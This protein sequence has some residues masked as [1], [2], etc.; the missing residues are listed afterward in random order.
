M[1]GWVK[2]LDRVLKGEA[3]RPEALREGMID[4]R[5]GGL[6]LL[7]VILG[8][9][10]GA[11]M[12]AFS[13][14]S[15][16][17]THRAGDGWLQVGFAASKVP[18]LFFLTLLITFPS[19]Y[20][21]NA[22]VGCRLAFS[23]VVRLIVSAMGVTIAVLASFGT[24]VVFFSLCTSSYPFMVLLNVVTFAVAGTLG[25][26]FLLQTLRRIGAAWQPPT[27]PI[28]EPVPLP[29]PGEPPVPPPQPRQGGNVGGVFTIWI[30][31]FGLIGAQMGWVLRPFIGAPNAPITFFRDRS[32]N[33]FEAVADHVGQLTGGDARQPGGAW[34]AT[35]PASEPASRR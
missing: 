30:V 25:M 10:Y 19:L 13:L 35:Q 15:R 17:G 28:A 9:L 29:V 8:G 16:W 27:R 33:F 24:I 20:V 22:L 31:V 11:C 23:A 12:G 6:T 3:T 14:M 7:L 1:I 5:A 32:G 21:F 34:P 4:V 26:G 2:A 18:M